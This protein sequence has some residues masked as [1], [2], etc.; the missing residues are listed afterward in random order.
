MDINSLVLNNC[1]SYRKVVQDGLKA[2]PK[3]VLKNPVFCLFLF[4]VFV[5]VLF[6]FVL[7][8][9]VL[10]CFVLFC[11]VLFCFVLFC[12]VLFCFVLFCF[13]FVIKLKI[14]CSL[15]HTIVF[16]FDKHV[17]PSPNT[18]KVM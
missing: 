4:S 3:M 16:K 5:F 8:C 1:F 6:C 2:L 12:F 7:F 15:D 11:F 18:N 17:G 13:V 10:F 9:F 14:S